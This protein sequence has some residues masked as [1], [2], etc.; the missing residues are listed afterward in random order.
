MENHVKKQKAGGLMLSGTYR[1]SNMHGNCKN[2]V[3]KVPG[4][5]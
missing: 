4:H 5:K 1:F 2:E 3:R